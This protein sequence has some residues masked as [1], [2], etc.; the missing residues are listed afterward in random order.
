MNSNF[1]KEPFGYLMTVDLYN[2]KEGVCD[3][4]ALCYEFLEK[5]VD[6]LG[7]KKQSPPFIFKSNGVLY[8]EKEGLSGWI[9]IIESGIQIHTLSLKRFISID[10]YSCRKFEPKNIENFVSNYFNPEFIEK[11]FIERGTKYNK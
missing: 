7:M 10:V 9:P 1:K 8:P 5:I 3:N 2:C 11:N 6:E 4:I